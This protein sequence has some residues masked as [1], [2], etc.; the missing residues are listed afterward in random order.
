MQQ[1]EK[2]RR[3]NGDNRADRPASIAIVYVGPIGHG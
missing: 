2:Q 3:M 1:G